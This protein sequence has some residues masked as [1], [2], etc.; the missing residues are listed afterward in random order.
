MS[1]IDYGE[2]DQ[3]AHAI[4]AE[5]TVTVTD[6]TRLGEAVA[7]ANAEQQILFLVGLARRFD[8]PWGPMQMEYI[9]SQTAGLAGVHYVGKFAEMLAD[10]FSTDGA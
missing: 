4:T 3:F 8:S 10:Y 7:D 2:D 5:T 1:P 9:R 6:W